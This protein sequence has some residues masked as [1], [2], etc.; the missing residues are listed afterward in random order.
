MTFVSFSARAAAL[1]QVVFTSLPY[2]PVFLVEAAL[3]SW[4]RAAA[5]VGFLGFVLLH[6]TGQLPFT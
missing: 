1:Q 5:L 3:A 4:W 2:R 6:K